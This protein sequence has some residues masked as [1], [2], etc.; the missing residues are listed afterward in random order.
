MASYSV[1]ALTL[2]FDSETGLIEDFDFGFVYVTSDDN[3][4]GISFFEAFIGSIEP[5]YAGIWPV[6]E[7]TDIFPTTLG[8]DMVFSV[9]LGDDIARPSFITPDAY[10]LPRYSVEY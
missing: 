3:D 2:D 10:I 8:G 7:S 9:S 1:S 6:Q 4:S 5:E